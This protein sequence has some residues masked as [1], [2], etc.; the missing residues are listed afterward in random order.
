MKPR[1]NFFQAAPEGIKAL[2]AVETQIQSSGLEQSLIELVRTR[3]SQ[4]NGCAFCINMHTQDARKHG[5]T[6]Q[7]LY[8]LNAWRE[9]PLYT[10]R[11]RAAL[12]WTEAVTLIS[13]THAPDDAYEEL[14][15][16]FSEAEA[17]NLTILIGTI[18]AWNRLAISFRA[19]PPVK[20]KAA[21]AA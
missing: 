10:D 18:N 2:T 3:A 16:H 1:M 14:R 13:E 6:E 17:V 12:A 8:L 4:I 5:E 9:A 21:T 11:E 19:V 20:A 15:K 7:R